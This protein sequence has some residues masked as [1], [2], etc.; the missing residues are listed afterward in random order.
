MKARLFVYLTALKDEL[1]L[2]KFKRDFN[3]I[4]ICVIYVEQ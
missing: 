2:S 3:E 1:F 4:C